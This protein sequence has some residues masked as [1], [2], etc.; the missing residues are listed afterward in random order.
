MNLSSTLADALGAGITLLNH[1]WLLPTRN[2]ISADCIKIPHS[3]SKTILGM[4]SF[5]YWLYFFFFLFCFNSF[6]DIISS[7]H[8]NLVFKE[9]NK[10]NPNK[11]KQTTNIKQNSARGTK[12]S[13]KSA[14]KIYENIICILPSAQIYLAIGCKYLMY[15]IFLYEWNTW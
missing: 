11:T 8:D 13:S 1:Q 12:I 10:Q 15:F 4:L 5:L 3:L 2:H 14:S 9:T 6:L 7:I